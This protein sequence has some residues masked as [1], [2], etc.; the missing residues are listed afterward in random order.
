MTETVVGRPFRLVPEHVVRA[1][2][3]LELRSGASVGVDVRMVLAGTLSVRAF[4]F[5]LRRVFVDAE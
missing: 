2:N 3:R 5:V 1:A 4:E